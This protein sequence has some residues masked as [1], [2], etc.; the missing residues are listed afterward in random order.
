MPEI[1]PQW[2]RESRLALGLTLLLALWELGYAGYRCAQLREGIVAYR[3]PNAD[4]VTTAV[5][6]WIVTV[7]LRQAV[8]AAQDNPQSRDARAARRMTLISLLPVGL[9]AV[10]LLQ[11]KSDLPTTA[12]NTLL[13]MGL[14]LTM[15]LFALVYLNYLPE[16]TSFMLRLSAITL[17][18]FLAVLGAV[19]QA[20]T[21]S[22]VAAYHN[23]NLIAAQQTIRFTPDA[24]G[25]YNIAQ[26]S[27]EYEEELG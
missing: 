22:F 10:L 16:Q 9:T 17:A 6:I 3:P 2:R 23:L 25:G 7:F 8:L 11:G 14:M 4:F 12:A 26:I 15:L 21:P 24:K 18:F 19:G 27:Y 1:R 13:S 5:F 20:M